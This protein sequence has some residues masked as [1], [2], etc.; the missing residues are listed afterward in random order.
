MINT[1]LTVSSGDKIRAVAKLTVGVTP[2]TVIPS[3]VRLR[4]E[5]EK[6]EV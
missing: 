2:I 3:T 6:R 1:G 4:I 5:T